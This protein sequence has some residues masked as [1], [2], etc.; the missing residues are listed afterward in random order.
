M[1]R[2]SSI[3]HHPVVEVAPVPF[4][5]FRIPPA[6]RGLP[7]HQRAWYVVVA[8]IVSA[9]ATTVPMCPQHDDAG[10]PLWRVEVV[11]DGDTVTCIDEAGQTV[12]IRLQGIDA[13][14]FDQPHGRTARNALDQKLASRRVRVTGTARDQHGRLLGTLWLDD[15]N[16]N[17][18]LIAEGHAWVFGG[19][20]PD[21]DLVDAEAAARGGRRPRG[22]GAGPV[23][24]SQW[25][26]EH[27]RQR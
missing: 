4:P 8:A 18:E 25:R 23:S 26:Q 2:L 24:P 13:P 12:K 15:R 3:F 21:L 17:R 20:A 6:P 16:L 9:V 14:E 5:K 22:G 1:V 27:P 19:F 7:R 11:N 10:R